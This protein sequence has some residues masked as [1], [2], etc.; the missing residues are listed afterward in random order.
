[1]HISEMANVSEE[2][3]NLREFFILFFFFSVSYSL[4]S[5]LP[6]KL[7]NQS[8]MSHQFCD[9][10]YLSCT[11]PV[12]FCFSDSD[13]LFASVIPI[14]SISFLATFPFPS[15]LHLLTDSLPTSSENNCGWLE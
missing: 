4:P 1:M 14:G 13:P 5:I 9:L 15:T 6:L 3:A 8:G 2:E 11:C 7:K 10:A 12:V